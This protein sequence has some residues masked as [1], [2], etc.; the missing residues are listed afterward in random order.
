M[1]DQYLSPGVGL[2]KHIHTNSH[3]FR[4]CVTVS[5]GSS[6]EKNRID[7]HLKQAV[8]LLGISKYRIGN[9]SLGICRLRKTR[10]EKLSFEKFSD[11]L[12]DTHHTYSIS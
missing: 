3:T 7:T 4:V 1:V 9:L 5:P 12:K 6:C 11:H 10:V 2:S 8:L